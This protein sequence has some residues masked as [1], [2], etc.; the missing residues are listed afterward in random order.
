MAV[1]THICWGGG[2]RHPEKHDLVVKNLSA[3]YAK[4]EALTQISFAAQCGQTL[5]LIGPNGA[6][7]STLIKVLAGLHTPMRGADIT[8]E[9]MPLKN[10]PHEIA[11]LPQHSEI[12][13]NFPITVRGLVEIGR[14]PSLGTWGK[15][16]KHDQEIVQKSLNALELQDLA[17]RQISSLSGGQKQRCFLARALA[18]EAHILLL[19][20]PFT[21]LDLPSS[22]TLGKLMKSLASE[23]RLIICSHHDLASVPDLYTN[24]MLLNREL[25]A[26]GKTA[27]VLN[28]ANLQLCFP[29]SHGS[30]FA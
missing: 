3:C 22:Q 10:M 23:G 6:G 4:V 14:Y 29:S 30:K 13:W 26:C 18:Q 8:W 21:G 1:N 27:D 2:H 15:F 17:D 16:S 5:A 12:N 25:F 7:K 20:E 24:V 19:D 28:P 9:G 11:Y